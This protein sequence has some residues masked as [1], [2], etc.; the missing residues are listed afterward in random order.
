VL[1]ANMDWV[2]IL[3][4]LDGDFSVRRIERYLALCHASPVASCSCS[5]AA[6][7]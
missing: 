3:M 7:R 5:R 2:F 6:P 1:A 4:A